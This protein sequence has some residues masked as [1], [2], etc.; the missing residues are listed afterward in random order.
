[1]GTNDFDTKSF[2]IVDNDAQ[3]DAT[4]NPH[5]R[6]G[7]I[8]ATD[9]NAKDPHTTLGCLRL[10]IERILTLNPRAKLFIFAPFYREKG[11]VQT[12]SWLKDLYINEDGKTIYD[13]ANAI[14]SVASEYNI[15]SFN[16]AKECGINSLTLSTYTYDDLHLNQYGGELI[17]N[18]VAQRIKV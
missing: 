10:I 17:G 2:T 6:F 11:T 1:M 8:N 7:T 15:P 4:S 14:V 16:T 18:Y 3:M 13:Y 9:E 12:N 5:P